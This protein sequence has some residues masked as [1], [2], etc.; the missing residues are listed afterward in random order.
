MP[1][2]D[3]YGKFLLNSVNSQLDP[4]DNNLTEMIGEK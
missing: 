2:F 4:G 1:V 3:V